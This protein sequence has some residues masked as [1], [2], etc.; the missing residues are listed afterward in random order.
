MDGPRRSGDNAPIRGPRTALRSTWLIAGDND[1]ASSIGGGRH[2]AGASPIGVDGDTNRSRSGPRPE[3]CW[4]PAGWGYG[5][6]ECCADMRGH[7]ARVMD[8]DIKGGET[9]VA[10]ATP[11]GQPLSPSGMALRMELGLCGLN[12]DNR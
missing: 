9:C 3:Y 2:T 5:D 6:G 12:G 8:E 7:G 4:P 10:A 1:L 11:L